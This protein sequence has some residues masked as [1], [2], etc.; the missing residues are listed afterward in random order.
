MS[1]SA[2]QAQRGL[3]MF[4]S[5]WALCFHNLN[6]VFMGLELAVN[7]LPFRRA[8]APF[9]ALYG[10]CY[11]CFSW[12]FH[13]YTGVWYYFFLDYNRPYPVR[14]PRC[15]ALSLSRALALSLACSLSLSPSLFLSLSR[16]RALSL[17]PVLTVRRRDSACLSLA[18][19]APDTHS[20]DLRGSVWPQV[21]SY[22]LL[23]LLLGAFFAFGAYIANEVKPR[24]LARVGLLEAQMTLRSRDTSRDTRA[25]D[26][27][28]PPRSRPARRRSS[29]TEQSEGSPSPAARRRASRSGR[30]RR[31]SSGAG[32]GSEG[33]KA[34][35]GA[36][37][38]VGEVVMGLHESG[39]WYDA[40]VTKAEGQTYVLRWHDGDTSDRVKTGGEVMA[41]DSRG[42]FSAGDRV[43]AAYGEEGW[44]AA[45]LVRRRGRKWEVEWED[46]DVQDT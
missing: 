43:M 8:H 42:P 26:S 46:G 5:F 31:R 35:G 19:R 10:V 16:T 37:S 34:G 24:A 30:P 45:Q 4:F 6:V 41:V 14:S 28:S 23:L 32:A 2:A 13:H 9:A 17:C 1:A 12:V 44:H 3:K 33:K 27:A 21:V 22:G 38:V 29:R 40:T 7:A 18:L 25:R 36:E 11:V 39:G 15:P 20:A